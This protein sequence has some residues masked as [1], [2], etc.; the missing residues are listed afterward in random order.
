MRYTD[1]YLITVTV[2]TT[3]ITLQVVPKEW[4]YAVPVAVLVV[5]FIIIAVCLVSTANI[6]HNC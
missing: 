3:T 1:S 6:T 4:R 2:H 5:G